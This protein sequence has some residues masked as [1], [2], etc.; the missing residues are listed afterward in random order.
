MISHPN[1][2]IMISNKYQGR[3]IIGPKRSEEIKSKPRAPDLLDERPGL[4]LDHLDPSVGPDGLSLSMA[5]RRAAGGERE[6]LLSDR[7]IRQKRAGVDGWEVDW[8]WVG[9]AFV[10]WEMNERWMG[11]G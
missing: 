1:D 3:R 6:V 4:A 11:G 5:R 2:L 8:R 10:G 9:G 7:R